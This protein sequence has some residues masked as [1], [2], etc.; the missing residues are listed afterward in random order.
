MKLYLFALALLTTAVC[1]NPLRNAQPTVDTTGMDTITDLQ[2]L[3]PN[4]AA[5]Y[6]TPDGVYHAVTWVPDLEDSLQT[7]ALLPEGAHSLRAAANRRCDHDY[8]DGSYR[9]AVKT[10]I[11]SGSYRKYTYLSTMLNSLP[12]DDYMANDLTPPITTAT[13]RVTE[14]K[15]NVRITRTYLYGYSKQADEDYHLIVGTTTNPA[16]ARY[17]NV[18]VSGAPSDENAA[19]YTTLSNVLTTFHTATGGE[20]CGSGY[21]MYNPPLRLEVRGSLFFDKEHYNEDIG[22]AAARPLTAWEVHPVTYLKFY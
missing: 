1:C 10:T 15:R 20:R 11:H 7:E 9:A 6:K 4:K 12:E 19:A 2:L 14:E 22:P 8:F 3:Q 17:F 5:L 16:T 18:E 21:L 13:L